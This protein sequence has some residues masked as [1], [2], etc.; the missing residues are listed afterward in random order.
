MN[1]TRFEKARIISARALQIS[2]GAPALVKATG[3]SEPY[4][5]SVDEYNKGTLPLTVFRDRVFLRFKPVDAKDM[6]EET[7]KFKKKE[8]TEVKETEDKKPA[9]EKKAA[10]AKTEKKKK[11]IKKSDE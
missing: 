2:F 10:A 7:K 5:I 1:F 3:H 4:D 9:K 11:K 8:S 6:E